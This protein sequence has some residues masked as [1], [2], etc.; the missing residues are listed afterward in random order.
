MIVAKRSTEE[1]EEDQ[2]EDDG[3]MRE[4]ESQMTPAH[5]IRVKL[6]K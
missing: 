5:A 1:E 2:G 3:V 4:V 6:W